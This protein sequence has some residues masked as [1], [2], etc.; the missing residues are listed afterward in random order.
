[1]IRPYDTADHADPAK[2][3]DKSRLVTVLSLGV[4]LRNTFSG[5]LGFYAQNMVM[6]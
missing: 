5:R 1:M 3:A 2:Q 6:L 4:T